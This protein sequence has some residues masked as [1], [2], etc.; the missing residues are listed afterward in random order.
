[1]SIMELGALGEF[2][3]FVGVILTLLYLGYQT[4]QNTAS[5]QGSAYQQWGEANLELNMTA[6]EPFQSQAL[7]VGNVD[8]ANL[9]NESYVSFAMWNL[10]LMQMA[11]TTDY[12]YRAGSLDRELWETE[13]NRTAG[14]LAFPGV[15]QWWD[16]GGNTQLTPR[17]V[18]LLES[19][20][21]N[22]AYWT[23]DSERGYFRTEEVAD[24]RPGE[25]DNR[26]E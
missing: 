8:S 12:L 10:G 5:M 22:I 1:M 2:L 13:I 21:S 11:Q 4:R 15:R 23:W 16:A 18:K 6:T 20:Q 24:V 14:I 26:A 17:F 25:P 9:S 7:D 19:T 3:G